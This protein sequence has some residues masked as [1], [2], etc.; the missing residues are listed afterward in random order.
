[1]KSRR[2]FLK[3]GVVGAVA[4]GAMSTISS[5]FAFADVTRKAFESKAVDQT[6]AAL[7]VTDA[8]ASGD[9]AI[10]APQVAE[11]GAS[12][13]V[14]ITSRIPGTE[15]IAVIVEGN[16]NPLATQVRV[17]AH[18][19]PFVQQRLKMGKNTKQVRVL[20]RANNKYYIATRPI[21]IS[22]GGCSS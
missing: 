22:I 6:L 13:P 10:Q 21:K 15:S 1:M 14:E 16:P 11:N 20:V 19:E 7:G 3:T 2:K 18:G 17:S 9:I 8:K 12:V 5:R 4:L